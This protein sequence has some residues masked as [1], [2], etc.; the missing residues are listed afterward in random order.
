MRLRLSPYQKMVQLSA[1]ILITAYLSGC[2][3]TPRQKETSTSVPPDGPTRTDPGT[4]Q[5]P[6][7]LFGEQF[8]SAEQQLSRFDWMAAYTT[9]ATI[10]QE[11][12]SATD[13][14]YLDYL[15]ARILYLG[16]RQDEASKHKT[17]CGGTE[18]IT[19]MIRI[20]QRSCAGS[21]SL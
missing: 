10:D 16:G 9:L 17:S 3:G 13:R 20:A 15:Q 7:S 1:L 2:G 11:Q 5:L 19:G 4:A 18:L 14:Q 8:T 12:T 6:P 21:H